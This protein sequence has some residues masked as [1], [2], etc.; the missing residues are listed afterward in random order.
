MCNHEHSENLASKL[1]GSLLGA[2]T[3]HLFF[4]YNKKKETFEE[5]NKKTR[6]QAKL[7]CFSTTGKGCEIEQWVERGKIF[8]H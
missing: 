5:L 8:K 7:Q 1:D 2:Y 3:E 4:T 6:Q